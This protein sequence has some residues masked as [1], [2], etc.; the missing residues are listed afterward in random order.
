MDLGLD[1][2]DVSAVEWVW[3]VAARVR[4]IH[5][6][7]R[8]PRHRVNIVRWHLEDGL[9]T[10]TLDR[11][12]LNPLSHQVKTELLDCLEEIAADPNVRCL[13]VHGAGARVLCRGGHQ[14]IPGDRGAPAGPSARHAGA[15]PV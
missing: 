4:F 9:V 14:G 8:A 6:R 7:F 10:L 13:I 1:P 11:P 5:Q 2:D 12:P 15:R 3:S